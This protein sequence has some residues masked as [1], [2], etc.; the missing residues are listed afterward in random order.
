MEH[1]A[2]DEDLFQE[3]RA[4]VQVADPVISHM[5][6][7][8]S[9]GEKAE[10]SRVLRHLPLVREVNAN[11][12]V[13]APAQKMLSSARHTPR[14]HGG[15]L[16]EA[17]AASS[18]SARSAPMTPRAPASSRSAS[19]SR[20]VA[21][22]RSTATPRLGSSLQPLA[23]ESPV[24][25]ARPPTPGK[26]EAAMLEAAELR[27]G[28]LMRRAAE[29]KQRRQEAQTQATARCTVQLAELGV[30]PKGKSAGD[31]LQL[32]HARGSG[33]QSKLANREAERRMN[34]RPPTPRSFDG[35]LTERAAREIDCAR[36]VSKEKVHECLDQWEV[37]FLGDMCRSL[38]A[39]NDLSQGASTTY[40]DSFRTRTGVARTKSYKPR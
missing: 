17:T 18:P 7:S 13:G 20:G 8:R 32:L 31:I 38:K 4:V 21:T 2:S 23:P 15:G 1:S 33:P 30:D 26:A 16:G 9:P 3:L 6:A 12:T 34:A 27:S 11:R 40:R 39:F 14:R 25:A 22:P 35:V 10:L 24:A 28:P 37:S 29:A 19:S 36:E 5:V